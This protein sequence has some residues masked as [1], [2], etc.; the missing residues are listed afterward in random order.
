MKIQQS[1][2][3]D[4]ARGAAL[5][6]SGGGGDPYIGSLLLHAELGK[7]EMADLI[8]VDDLDDED[9]VVPVAMMGA[10]TVLLEKFP[11]GA[12]AERVLRKVEE[13]LGRPAKAIIAAEIGGGN[14]LL[15]LVLGAQLGLPVIDGDGMGR[16]F[17]ELHMVTFNIGGVDISPMVMTDEHGNIVAIDGVSGK[18]VEWLARHVVMAMGGAGVIALYPMTGRQAKDTTVQSTITIAKEIGRTIRE[19]RENSRDPFDALGDYLR[20]TDYYKESRVLMDGKIVD[21]DRKTRAGFA[22]GVATIVS[23]DG[24]RTM[25]IEFQ[26][27]NLVARVDDET[28]AMVPDLICILD[29]E[30]AEPITTE[31]LKYGQRVKVIAIGAP[32]ILT[33]E[34]ALEVLGP[35]GFGY[36]RP[37]QPIGNL[38]TDVENTA[39]A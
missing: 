3:D 5:L 13:K 38:K 31:G 4:L 19:A 23:P 24:A 33:T 26:N 35:K 6:G 17:P 37:Y 9:L 30:T 32:P 12:E 28:L 25:E 20:T 21:L 8:D 1:D 2:I 16:A 18:H 11:N 27:E 36:D 34:S 10:P 14:A 22:V 29:R 15:P 39:G 7:G